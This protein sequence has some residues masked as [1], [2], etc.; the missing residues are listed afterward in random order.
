MWADVDG[1]SDTTALASGL[2]SIDHLPPAHNLPLHDCLLTF[3]GS[4]AMASDEGVVGNGD[5][6]GHAKQR[7]V[8]VDSDMAYMV[9]YRYICSVGPVYFELKL[10]FCCG[11]SWK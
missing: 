1:A 4:L 6:V 3:G 7:D 10:H 2:S 8:G 9:R 11:V 5:V